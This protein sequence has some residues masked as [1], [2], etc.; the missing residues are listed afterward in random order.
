MALKTEE[1]TEGEVAGPGGESVLVKAD[2]AF[3][4]MRKREDRG[5]KDK[6]L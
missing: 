2:G 6:N 5:K 1:E 3:Q 4:H